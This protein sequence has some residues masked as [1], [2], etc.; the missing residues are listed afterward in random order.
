MVDLK[1][2]RIIGIVWGLILFTL[3][4]ALTIFGITYKNKSLKY[5]DLEKDFQKSVEQ[6]VDK[7]F[8]YPE[9][10]KTLKVTLEEIQA[11]NIL[12]ELKVDEDN[13]T[14]YV[15]IYKKNGIFHYEP[16]IKCQKYKTRNYDKN[17]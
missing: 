4:I 14:G 7:N 17:K 8:L 1:K 3:V 11:E 6:Y 2:M 5:K 16:Y 10:N 12:S 13:C 9:D 15:K